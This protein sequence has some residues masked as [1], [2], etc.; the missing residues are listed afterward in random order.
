MLGSTRVFSGLTASLAVVLTLIL[1]PIG[2]AA[3]TGPAAYTDP[4]G[5]AKSAP[6]L[7]K[8]TLGLDAASG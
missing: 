3:T 6:D 8:V 1:A 7:A 2:S 5:D 4:A